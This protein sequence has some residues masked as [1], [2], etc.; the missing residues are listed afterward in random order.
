MLALFFKEMP[1]SKYKWRYSD[2]LTSITSIPN[3]AIPKKVQ[4]VLKKRKGNVN[5]VLLK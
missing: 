1:R 3:H 2:I 4:T 5:F